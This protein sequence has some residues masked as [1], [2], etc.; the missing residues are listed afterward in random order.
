MPLS[1]DSFHALSHH[2]NCPVKVDKLVRVQ[3]C[4]TRL[5]AK[6]V[7]KLATRREGDG[8]L[9]D[10]SLIVY[11]SNMSNS[12]LHEH[13]GLPLALLGGGRGRLAGDRHI[14]CPDHTA[15]ANLHVALLNKVGIPTATF[16]DS[17]GAL[18]I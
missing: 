1:P 9:L 10:H 13:T 5:F 12:N 16:G 17:T 7:N 11:G 14:R 3:S 4:N 15:L 2:G 18:T 6:F 8:S